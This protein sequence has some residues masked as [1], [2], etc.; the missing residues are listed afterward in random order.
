MIILEGIVWTAVAASYLTFL[1][2][3]MNILEGTFDY[4]CSAHTLLITQKRTTLNSYSPLG[5]LQAQDCV[6]N[7]AHGMDLQVIVAAL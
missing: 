7:T 1:F 3:V 6:S 2:I 4:S 5:R